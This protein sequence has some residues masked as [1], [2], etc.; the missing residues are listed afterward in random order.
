MV[1]CCCL[2][3]STCIE[4]NLCNC[5][6]AP[7]ITN[8]AKVLRCQLPRENPFY[9]YEPLKMVKSQQQLPREVLAAK[10]CHV[11]G[12]AADKIC[13]GCKRVHYCTRIHQKQGWKA[14]HKVQ[15][16]GSQK[17]DKED[18]IAAKIE[19]VRNFPLPQSVFPEFEIVIEEERHSEEGKKTAE[20]KQK[21]DEA[22]LQ[23]YKDVYVAGKLTLHQRRSCLVEMNKSLFF[24]FHFKF[25]PDIQLTHKTTIQN[26]TMMPG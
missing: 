1:R 20:Q 16:I 5:L 21:D 24:F 10:T 19:D 17:E 12:Q 8:S 4:N 25:I 18:R 23:K 6:L 22:L 26:L 7:Y 13:A 2:R 15:C 9:A 3:G 14:G 11:C